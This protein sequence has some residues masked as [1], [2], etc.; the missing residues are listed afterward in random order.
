MTAGYSATP[1]PKK[2]GIKPE[3][4]VLLVDAPDT[5]RGVELAGLPPGVTV[6]TEPAGPA[7]DVVVL[8]VR[9]S[10]ELL[11]RFEPHTR[12]ITPAGRLWVAWPRKAGGF[13]SDV[14]ENAIRDHALE[15]G[16]VDN[17]V[18]AISEAWS[19]LQVVHRLENRP[20]R[21]TR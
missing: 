13:A 20:A 4:R 12:L 2:L 14:T 18:A 9:S 8:F 3:S 16:L 19:G 5:F 7:Y 1:L 10:D 21:A 6:E 11:E 15:L 17:K